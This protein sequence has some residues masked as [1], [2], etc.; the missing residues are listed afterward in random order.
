[1]DTVRRMGIGCV[2]ALTPIL[3][4]V[5]IVDLQ[6]TLSN[7]TLVSVVFYLIRVAA[8]CGAACIV[9]FLNSDEVRPVK[10]FQL[11]VAAPALLTG[12]INGA[13]IA[14][15]NG[16]PPV[17]SPP[18]QSMLYDGPG[19][20]RISFMPSFVN[21]AYA[22]PVAQDVAVEDCTKAKQATFTQQALK[23]LLGLQPDNQWYVVVGSNPTAQSATGDA[24][25]LNRRYVG[26]FTAKVCA[27]AGSSDG[28][29]RVVIGEGMSYD[30]ASKL[31]A[32]AVAAGLPGDAWV[33]NPLLATR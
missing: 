25:L 31:R 6:T 9:I 8:L 4:N 20:E 5:L 15:G 28:R 16:A 21:A 7:V 24:V 2:G 13:V 26:K 29:F 30:S 1:P 23:G 33:W 17:A 10:L 19:I 11:G 3:I 27:P 14:K 32:D 18:A 22:Q 12:M